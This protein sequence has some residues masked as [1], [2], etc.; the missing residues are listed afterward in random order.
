[1]TSNASNG[2][3]ERVES[4]DA[5][6]CF[7][8][9]S[10]DTRTSVGT[11][12]RGKEREPSRSSCSR[13]FRAGPALP[14]VKRG[15]GALSH[16]A[17]A[18]LAEGAGLPADRPGVRRGHSTI[19]RQRRSTCRRAAF[20][21]RRQWALY[22]CWQVTNMTGFF[23]GNV[24]PAAWSLEFAVRSA[25]WRWSRPL[26]RD[27]AEHR[28]GRRRRRRRRRAGRPA[29]EA[30]PDRARR[31]RHVRRHA[32]GPHEGAMDATL[33]LWVVI[34]WSGCSTTCRGCRSSP[35]SP[36]GRC[37]R[38]WRARSGTCP[39][40]C[41]TALIVPTD[42]RWTQPAGPRWCSIPGIA[43]AAIAGVVL[44]TP[45]LAWTMGTGM[46]A[47]WVLQAVS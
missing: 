6:S 2:I 35:C 9:Q 3:G 38:C 4:A 43:A 1:M 39:Q 8:V 12:E 18:A 42:R 7:H 34:W 45:Q 30:Q 40:R 28:R 25:S 24:I 16:G 14:H 10:S 44:F 11:V 17:A 41:W 23:A 32:R 21:G 33:K 27:I 29:D 46:A 26:L 20:P 19:Q 5:R 13:C 31:D 22:L 36:G 37:R 47:L 15:D